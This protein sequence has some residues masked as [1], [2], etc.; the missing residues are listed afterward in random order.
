MTSSRSGRIARARPGDLVQ[1]LA[2][3]VVAAR[4]EYSLRRSD[5]PTTVER[6]GL[7]LGSPGTEA[8]PA[9]RREPLPRWA[10]RRARLALILMRR[11]P[12]GDTCLRQSLVIGNR[13]ASLSPQLFIGVRASGDQ[14][15]ISAHAWLKV[16]GIDIDPTSANYVAFDFA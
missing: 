10:I 7:R 5:L 15:S 1:A 13:L 9:P 11:W 12:F 3:L 16:C 4:I 14:R 6:F 2:I 8:D